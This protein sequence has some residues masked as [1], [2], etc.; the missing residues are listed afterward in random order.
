MT[1]LTHSHKCDLCNMDAIYLEK[2]GNTEHY[3]CKH[4]SSKNNQ[5]VFSE[6]TPLFIVFA[7]VTV[8][9]YVL[10]INE[11]FSW[12][13]YMMDWMG[14]FFIIFGGLKLLDLKGF[15]KNFVSYDPIAEK[16]NAYGYVFPFLEIILGYMYL[17]GYMF[18]WQNLIVMLLALVGMFSAY[19]I[20][21]NKSEIRCVCMGTLLHIPTTWATFI[22]NTLMLIM[23]ILM[24]F[25]PLGLHNSN[26]N[27]MS[28]E[29]AM[30]MHHSNN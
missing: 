23:V 28:T 4:H 25:A 13:I 18:L 3:Y 19:K 27:N 1:K 26:Q 2:D 6:L 16:I 10:K 15:T 29:E 24:M 20:I 8:L 7:L 11:N 17:A 22:E 21:K 9:A 5:S 12:S 30:H 14:I